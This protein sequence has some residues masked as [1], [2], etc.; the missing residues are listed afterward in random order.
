MTSLAKKLLGQFGWGNDYEDENSDNIGEYEDDYGDEES[1]FVHPYSQEHSEQGVRNL[2]QTRA[3]YSGLAIVRAEPKDMDQANLVANEIKRRKPVLLN[4]LKTP[5][6]EATRIRDF[7]YGVSYGVDGRMCC[8][9]EWVFV[10]S[11][12]D[13]PLERLS[14]DGQSSSEHYYEQ[15]TH[16]S[17]AD[18]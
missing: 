13:M 2:R 11:P 8:I 16:R 10:C 14:M 4:L 6:S 17:A 5:E 3:D 1:G 7:I 15:R 18:L 12:H 9:T